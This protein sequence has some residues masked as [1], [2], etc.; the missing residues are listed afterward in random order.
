[1]RAG[2]PPAQVRFAAG[3]F[4]PGSNPA[5]IRVFDLHGRVVRDLWS[6]S[7][8]RGQCLTVSWDGSG[9]DGR[10]MHS[11]CYF[12]SLDVGGEVTTARVAW[13]R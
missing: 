4:L 8:A 13:L 2:G 1:V 12:L 11:G 7:L 3:G 5:G 9:E 10:R 6:G